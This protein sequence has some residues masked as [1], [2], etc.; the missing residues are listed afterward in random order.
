MPILHCLGK[1]LYHPIVPLGKFA[2]CTYEANL[3]YATKNSETGY[4]PLIPELE[5]MLKELRAERP[6]EPANFD[7]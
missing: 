3:E 7:R 4:V 5:Q 1:P 2:R 6:N